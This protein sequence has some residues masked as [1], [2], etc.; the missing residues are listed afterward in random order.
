MSAATHRGR[1]SGGSVPGT[2]LGTLTT[3]ISHPP[4]RPVR[5]TVRRRR[6]PEGTLRA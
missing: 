3:R 6:T 5:P 1:A 2:L 4:A